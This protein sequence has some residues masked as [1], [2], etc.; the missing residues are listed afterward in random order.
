MGSPQ[1]GRGKRGSPSGP[2][3]SIL[4]KNASAC[5]VG[6]GHTR[7]PPDVPLRQRTL[8]T[9]QGFKSFVHSSMLPQPYAASSLFAAANYFTVGPLGAVGCSLR[10]AGS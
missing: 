5:R 4:E 8:E 10:G 2:D 6:P 7:R 3:G 9:D 1:E